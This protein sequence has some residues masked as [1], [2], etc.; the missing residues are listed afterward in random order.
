M[1][2]VEIIA[3]KKRKNEEIITQEKKE[4]VHMLE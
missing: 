1:A 2:Q 4:Y 3:A